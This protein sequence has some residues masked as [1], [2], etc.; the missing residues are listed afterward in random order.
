MTAAQPQVQPQTDAAPAGAATPGGRPGHAPGVGQSL[1]LSNNASNNDTNDTHSTI[2]PTLPATSI[3]T[4]AT[5]R[6]YLQE[7]RDALTATG[8]TGQAQE[9]L[10]MAETRSLDRVIPPDQ[11]TGPSQSEIV[12]RIS[13]ARAA[14]GSGDIAQAILL[15]DQA[16]K[17]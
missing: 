5:P 6:A 14:L 1:P 15:I 7:A 17:D 4:E 2:A 11:T 12:G 3:G 13:A 16:L 10:E 9:A 8:R